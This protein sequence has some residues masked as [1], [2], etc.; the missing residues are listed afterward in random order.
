MNLTGTGLLR[1]VLCF[2]GVPQEAFGKVEPLLRLAELLT[3]LVHLVLEPFNA[4][5]DT[6]FV[7]DPR[8]RHPSNGSG[9]E[10]Q[11]TANPCHHGCK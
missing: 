3:K 7:P 9:N 1:K 11:A 8:L 6:R 10:R 5:A 4:L 2:L